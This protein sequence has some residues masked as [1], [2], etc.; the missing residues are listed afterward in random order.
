MTRFD[1]YQ[2]HRRS[3]RMPSYDYGSD[4]PYF[5]T[6]CTFKRACVFGDVRDDAVVLNSYGAIVREE[7]ERSTEIRPGFVLHAF[8]VMPNHLHALADLPEVEEGMGVGETVGAHSCAPLH[9]GFRRQG[10]SLASFV[11]QFKA[12]VTRRINAE[13]ATPGQAVWQRNYYEHIVR[14]D[15]DL[16][17]IREYI[18]ENP[19]RWAEDEYY[20]A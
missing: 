16:S 1:R 18:E 5:L 7:L 19:R 17:R 11:A 4:G 12:T 13:R 14:D 15:E 6:V 2:H 3:I 9:A 8:V 20:S 10:R